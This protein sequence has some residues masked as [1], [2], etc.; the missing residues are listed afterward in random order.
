MPAPAPATPRNTPVC[1]ARPPSPF[2]AWRRPRPAR[3][4]ALEPHVN[5]P[6]RGGVGGGRARAEGPACMVGGAFIGA[7]QRGVA[8]TGPSVG[9]ETVCGSRQQQGLAPAPVP[10]REQKQKAEKQTAAE[11][12]R[13]RDLTLPSLTR[14]PQP[15]PYQRRLAPISVPCARNSQAPYLHAAPHRSCGTRCP[16]APPRPR[17]RRRA[18]RARL[19]RRGPLPTR[20]RPPTLSAGLDPSLCR[21]GRHPSPAGEPP[22]HRHARKHRTPPPPTPPPSSC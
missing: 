3:G 16:R 4:A 19:A 6:A 2:A 1:G 21:G 22:P 7:Q 9:R 17:C 12:K 8:D 11:D 20:L 13:A 5:R 10:E 14:Y 15:R 18:S